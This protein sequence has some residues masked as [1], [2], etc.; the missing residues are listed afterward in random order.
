M[1]SSLHYVSESPSELLN[2][3]TQYLDQFLIY[4]S[5]TTW[6]PF[7]H[8]G[9]ENTYHSHSLAI[10]L[11]VLECTL[12]IRACRYGYLHRYNDRSANNERTEKLLTTRGLFNS[13]YAQKALPQRGRGSTILPLCELFAARIRKRVITRVA[14]AARMN[15]TR[16]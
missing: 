14:I 15:T 16:A 8:E 1:G 3:H 7:A 5:L 13:A 10:P 9:S 2:G 6:V 12:I 4:L 11:G